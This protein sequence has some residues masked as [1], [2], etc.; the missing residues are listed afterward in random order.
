GGGN[1]RPSACSLTCTPSPT[2]PR[3]H[4]SRGRERFLAIHPQKV[5]CHPPAEGSVP[6]TRRKSVC[7]MLT[8]H[9]PLPLARGTW[10]LINTFACGTC[11]ML[12]TTRGTLILP[13]CGRRSGGGAPTRALHDRFK[14][15][16]RLQRR[17][18]TQRVLRQVLEHAYLAVQSQVVQHDRLH[19]QVD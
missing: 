12:F 16:Q 13:A 11:G 18:S 17:A 7:L 10:E 5:P 15:D 9:S 19:E 14:R 1:L 2:L 8:A 4:R 3:S 6:S